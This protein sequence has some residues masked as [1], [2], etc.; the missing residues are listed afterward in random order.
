M[1]CTLKFFQIKF[2]L[3]NDWYVRF[4]QVLKLKFI[5]IRMLLC[6]ISKWKSL[7]LN[8]FHFPRFKKKFRDVLL[9]TK[10]NIYKMLTVFIWTVLILFSLLTPVFTE[11]PFC[12]CKN[13]IKR[14]WIPKY[15]RVANYI[16][17]TIVSLRVFM[18]SKQTLVLGLSFNHRGGQTFFFSGKSFHTYLKHK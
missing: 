15:K 8:I 11:S 6:K 1:N 10:P 2:T 3:C 17:E 13:T 12:I 14:C 18:N 7:Q 9:D 4:R 5:C 16:H